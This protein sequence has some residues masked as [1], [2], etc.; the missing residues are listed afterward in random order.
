MGNTTSPLG[1]LSKLYDASGALLG[2]VDSEGTLIDVGTASGSSLVFPTAVL[3]ASA[4]VKGVAGDPGN[5]IGVFCA[6]V[7]GGKVTIRDG[8]SVAGALIPGL[9][10]GGASGLALTA[11]QYLS[12]GGPVYCANGIYL[13]ISGTVSVVVLYQ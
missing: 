6:S 5:F 8:G 13:E 11:G 7:S 9:G 12:L 10:S 4:V 2:L 3:S 1:P